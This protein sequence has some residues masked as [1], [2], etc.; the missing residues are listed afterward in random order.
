MNSKHSL[1][2]SNFGRELLH[3]FGFLWENQMMKMVPAQNIL[4]PTSCLHLF[5][6]L[7]PSEAGC[8]T[9]LQPWENPSYE[10][11]LLP[12]KH[13]A[14][15]WGRWLYKLLFKFWTGFSS[16]F[17][18]RGISNLS[19]LFFYPSYQIHSAIKAPQVPK[20][21]PLGSAFFGKKKTVKCWYWSVADASTK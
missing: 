12:Q 17:L 11:F 15:P 19:P 10:D 6:T 21:F 16:A 18:H 5:P 7:L 4:L 3:T 20:S 8:C 14:D 2:H 9:L 1:W 13:D